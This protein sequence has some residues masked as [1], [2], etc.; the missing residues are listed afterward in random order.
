MI[1]SVKDRM[2]VNL[3][4]TIE[5]DYDPSPSPVKPMAFFTPNVPPEH[6][7][8]VRVYRG[9]EDITRWLMDDQINE[10]ADYAIQRYKDEIR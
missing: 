7:K 9:K 1:I 4:V 5:V 3:E 2:D 8:G 10:L 6:I